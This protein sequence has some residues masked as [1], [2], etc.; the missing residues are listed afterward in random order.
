VQ[1]IWSGRGLW[2]KGGQIALRF[3]QRLRDSGIAARLHIYSAGPCI[4]ALQEKAK[5]ADLGDRVEFHAPVPRAELLKIYGRMH[6]FVYP[7]THDSSSSAIP[8][9]YAMGLPSMTLGIG[10]V[11]VAADPA[12]GLNRAFSSLE[13]WLSAGVEMVKGW[14]K[15]PREWLAASEA[16]RYKSA[17]FAFERL[18]KR[19]AEDLA[20]Y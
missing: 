13:D 9:A 15:D 3:L 4:P 14:Q 19:V 18:S 2:W 5:R 20:I 17:D 10:G 11:G 7:T 6:L 16:A 1:L 12:A 8:E